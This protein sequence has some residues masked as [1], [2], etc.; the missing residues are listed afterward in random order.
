MIENSLISA[1]CDI[2]GTVIRSVLS[3]G[4][5]VEEGA[6]VRDSILLH[7]VVVRAGATVQCAILDEKAVIGAGAT[8]GRLSDAKSEEA[9][10]EE[11][12]LIGMRAAIEAGARVK[13][14]A[15]IEP[16]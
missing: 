9:S 15:R 7:D 14:G 2:R 10:S 12:T 5:T 6:T 1:G 13:A 11:I 3:P 4:V 16:A 8:V